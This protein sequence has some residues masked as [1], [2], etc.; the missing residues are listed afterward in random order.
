MKL[1]LLVPLACT[2][3]LS[4]T[5]AEQQIEAKILRMVILTTGE[6]CILD[7]D[8]DAAALKVCA[9]AVQAQQ[10]LADTLARSKMR[11]A[12]SD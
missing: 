2:A 6:I 9:E 8:D 11:D 12:G 1:S 7:A 5:P 10:D 4:C 3:L